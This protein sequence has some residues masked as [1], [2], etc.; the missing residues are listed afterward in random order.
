MFQRH[1]DTPFFSFRNIVHDSIF[2]AA[3]AP[4]RTDSHRETLLVGLSQ[5]M[6][7]R[8]FDAQKLTSASM[9]VKESLGEGALVEAAGVAAGI[10]AAS[11][12]VDMVGKPAIPAAFAAVMKFIL[13]A[14][15]WIL[16]FF[17]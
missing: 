5:A 11:R 12:C 2:R 17:R 8:P 6:A 16:S 9:A 14:I 3:S 15:N 7:A 10:E 4:S 13:C 1:A